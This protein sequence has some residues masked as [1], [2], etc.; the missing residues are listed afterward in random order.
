MP[1]KRA[2][3]RW[4]AEGGG[5]KHQ[6]PPI[7]DRD[8]VFIRQRAI[9]EQAAKELHAMIARRTA[10]YIATALSNIAANIGKPN[11]GRGVSRPVN[12]TQEG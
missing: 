11:F 7:E 2:G 12:T 9:S 3:D 1:G 6:R 8:A 10:E 5:M 4:K